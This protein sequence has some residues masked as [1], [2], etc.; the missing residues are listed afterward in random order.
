MPLY[1]SR[2]SYT[3]ETWARLIG[4]PE[5]RRKAAAGVHRVG[6]RE[7][8]RLLVRVRRPRRLHPV[9]GAR[10]RVD[11]RGRAGDQQRWRAQLARDDGPPDRR[12]D[13]RGA[14]QGRAGRSTERPGPSQLTHALACSRPGRANGTYLRRDGRQQ[15]HRVGGGARARRTRRARRVGRAGYGQGRAGRRADRGAGSASVAELDLSDLDQV[16]ACAGALLDCH[17]QLD[18]LVCNAGVM[19]GPLLLSAQGFERQMATNHLGHAAL[20]AALWP[21][22]RSSASRVVLVASTEARDGRLSPRTTRAEL[23]DPTPYDGRQVYR[24]HEAGQPAVRPGV[25][26]PLRRAGSTGRCDRRAPRAPAR[27]TCSPASSRRPAMNG[28]A[29]PASSPLACCCSRPRPA[30]C[31]HSGRSTP[32]R[33]AVP[34]SVRPGSA[35]SAARRSCSTSTPPRRTR[36]RPAPVGA[37]PE[38]VLARPL[39]P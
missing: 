23:V 20:V 6:R 18:A 36:R 1:L 17:D 16:A 10:Q 28:W 13:D 32:G 4:N 22:L 21:L 38:Q 26:P 25:A 2:F 14:A 3:P 30:R 7:A 8:P 24:Q 33:R 27:R 35:S 15:R 12:R 31:P 39:P 37:S 11:G 29:V 34:L 19:G 9:G 5:D